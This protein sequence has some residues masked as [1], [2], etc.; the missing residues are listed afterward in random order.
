[1]KRKA[2]GD[3]EDRVDAD[4]VAWA[5]IARSERFCRGGDAAQT[6]AIERHPGGIGGGALFDLDERQH[7]STARDQVDFP[8]A[9]LDPPPENPPALES[10]PPSGE[11]LG[12]SAAPFGFLPAQVADPRASARA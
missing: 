7:V 8:A 4:V 2:A 5:G 10:E 11:G 6:M 3:N 12:T 9:Q 1:M